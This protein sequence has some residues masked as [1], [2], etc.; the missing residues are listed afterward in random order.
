MFTFCLHLAHFNHDIC[1][2]I[3]HILPLL[4]TP[5]LH[6]SHPPSLLLLPLFHSLILLLPFSLYPST[7]LSSSED[8]EEDE[9]ELLSSVFKNL[10]GQK[11]YVAPKDLLDWDIVLELMGEVRVY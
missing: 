8:D 10:A 7:S 1:E 4:F 9:Q 6:L 11:S 5:T 2:R 3:K